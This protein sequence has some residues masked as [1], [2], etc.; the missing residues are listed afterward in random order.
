MYQPTANGGAGCETCHNNA[1]N[2]PGG[3]YVGGDEAALYAEL[4]AE[5]PSDNGGTGETYRTNTQ[6]PE[7]SLVLIN[8]LAGNAEPHPVKIFANNADPRYQT[9]YQWLVQGAQNN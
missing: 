1:A 9:I 8:P 2:P 5:T 4:T 3:F 7:R 6:Y